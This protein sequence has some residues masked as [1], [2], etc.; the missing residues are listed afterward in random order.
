M[1]N[2]V[3]ELRRDSSYLR[4]EFSIVNERHEQLITVLNK[5]ITHMMRDPVHRIQRQ[6]YLRATD[7]GVV[8]G[9]VMEGQILLQC[10]KFVHALF[11]IYVMNM[12]L[13]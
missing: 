11:T 8:E 2:L 13:G 6:K 1:N 4:S 12:N 5:N 3:V 9:D 10:C 7:N